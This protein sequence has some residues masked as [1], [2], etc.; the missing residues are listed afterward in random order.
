MSLLNDATSTVSISSIKPASHGIG[1]E[2]ASD[3]DMDVKLDSEASFFDPDGCRST[4]K[5]QG[6][7]YPDKGNQDDTD[8]D[9]GCANHPCSNDGRTN[10]ANKNSNILNIVDNYNVLSSDYSRSTEHHLPVATY[11]LLEF[12]NPMISNETPDGSASWSE[13]DITNCN[14]SDSD[15][16]H[17]PDLRLRTTPIENNN[18][19]THKGSK[20]LF[21]HLDSDCDAE[22]RNQTKI[23][24]SQEMERFDDQS[25]HHLSIHGRSEASR[26]DTQYPADTGQSLLSRVPNSKRQY[27]TATAVGVILGS[28]STFFLLASCNG[29]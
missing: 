11:P 5:Y 29:D 16:L 22:E 24:R 15:S 19:I 6:L 3:T 9:A 4:E 10:D 21:A 28:V 27:A 2:D 14:S 17:T 8:H 20:R 12:S 1:I 25:P 7:D 26:L 13:E 18:L 23:P